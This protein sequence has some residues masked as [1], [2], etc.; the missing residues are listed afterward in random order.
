ME[1]DRTHF[2]A[3]QPTQ[4]IQLALA[5]GSPTVRYTKTFYQYL[6]NILSRLVLGEHQY[7]QMRMFSKGSSGER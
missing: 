3:T 5:Y 2:I 6:E 7:N 1:K 4:N